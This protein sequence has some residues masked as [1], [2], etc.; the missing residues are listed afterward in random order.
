M[1]AT[2]FHL[3]LGYWFIFCPIVALG[4]ALV[5]NLGRTHQEVTVTWSSYAMLKKEVT[6]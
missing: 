6:Q 3:L 1:I 2:I 5:E 4:V